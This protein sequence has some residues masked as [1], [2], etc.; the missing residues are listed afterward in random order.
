MFTFLPEAVQTA[1]NYVNKNQVYE[2][3]LRINLPI[4]INYR[5][6][7]VY[8]SAYG[9][10]NQRELALICEDL[11]VS[12]CVYRAGNYAVYSIEEQ[13]KQGFITTNSGVRIGISGEYV[14]ENGK[15]LTIRNLTSLCIRFPHAIIGAGNLVFQSCMADRVRN[16]LIVSP[17]GFGKTTILRDLARQIAKNTKR[18]VL[19]CDERGEIALGDM[20]ETCDVIRF[21][22]KKTAFGAGIRAMR[23]D[24][25]VT[26]ELSLEDYSVIKS[27]VYTGVKVLATAHLHN[28]QDVPKDFFGVFERFIVLSNKEIGQISG[29]YN[30]DGVEIVY[31]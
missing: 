18:N 16:L 20:G 17:P 12:E 25:I 31:G 29:I 15:P 24:I 19:I 2:I 10:T 3:R 13:L 7:Y 28:I 5:G 23:P 1:L 6:D 14:M 30:E 9:I 27:A 11:D 21:C 8:L 22:D 4:F 26:D